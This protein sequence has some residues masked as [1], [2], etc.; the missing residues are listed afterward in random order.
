MEARGRHADS[1]SRGAAEWSALGGGMDLS[2]SQG[3]RDEER[4]FWGGC[5][6]SGHPPHPASNVIPSTMPNP[7][8]FV[9]WG[10]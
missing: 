10:H 1:N 3:N 8:L 9:R 2:L 7:G 4:A 5:G 6:C